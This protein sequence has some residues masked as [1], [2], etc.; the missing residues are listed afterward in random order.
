[1]GLDFC[2]Y[3]CYTIP[4][5]NI[6]NKSIT[7]SLKVLS[8]FAFVSIFVPFNQAAAAPTYV[9]GH[10]NADGSY[11]YGDFVWNNS[12]ST[13]AGTNDNP[14]PTIDSI[15]PKSGAVNAGTKNITI[16]GAGFI[17]SSV[18]R[19]NDSTRTTT[20]IDPS[21]LLVKIDSNDTYTYQD[22]GGFFITVFNGAPGGGYSN[23]SFFTV[24][25]TATS[26]NTNEADNSNASNLAASAIFGSNGFL[27]SGL[28]QWVIL[29]I[30]ILLIV[31]FTRKV[32]GAS[33]NYHES[34][35]KHA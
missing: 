15:S 19:V 10:Y 8:I 32:F 22:N 28:I 33:K 30:I 7:L 5:K 25:N 1:M 24:S 29:A 26:T 23:A 35:L 14:V 34:P 18:V 16:T 31:I 3:K 9:N 12:T 17:P 6:N 21:H 20:F 13:N 2:L 27:P 4:M 11:T